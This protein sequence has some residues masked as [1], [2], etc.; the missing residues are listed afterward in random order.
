MFNVPLIKINKIKVPIGALEAFCYKKCNLLSK[1]EKV[2]TFI[3][4]PKI[5]QGSLNDV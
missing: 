3:I 4:L 1:K 5:H 2:I